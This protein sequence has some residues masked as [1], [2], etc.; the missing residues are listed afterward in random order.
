M[1]V[2]SIVAFVLRKQRRDREFALRGSGHEVARSL[3]LF[4][5]A[6][7]AEIGGAWLIWQGSKSTRAGRGSAL[8][9][10]R[11]CA[12]SPSARS[13][14]V[15]RRL[16][17]GFG[18]FVGVDVF[19]VISGFLIT[20]AAAPRARAT[21]PVSARRFYAR[22][23]RRLLPAAAV[24]WSS[25]AVVAC[26]AAAPTRR[27]VGGDV[28]CGGALR[29]RTS[30]R[31]RAADYLAEDARR[32]R[33]S[34][35]GRSR[36]RS[37]STSSG[38]CWSSLARG[39][40]SAV[41]GGRACWSRGRRHRRPLLVSLC[42]TPSAARP[43]FFVSTTR[44]LGAGGRRAA[45]RSRCPRPCSVPACGPRRLLA[46]GPGW[47]HRLSAHAGPT[48]LARHGALLPV[49][50]TAAGIWPAAAERPWGAA[51]CSAWAPPSDR[52]AVLLALPLALADPRRRPGHLGRP[53]GPS[54]P[55][56]GGRLGGPGLAVLPLPRAPAAPHPAAP[57]PR[58]RPALL[59]GAAGTVLASVAGAALSSRRTRWSTPSRPRHGRRGAGR[60]C[61]FAGP[62]ATPTPTGRRSGTRRPA[63]PVTPC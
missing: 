63:P 30:L 29:R 45:W 27:D 50:G 16:R 5:A 38:R 55:G 6:A 17:P 23:A 44:G 58:P 18:G 26:S 14:L 62:A 15:P 39:S 56:R 33:S 57:R 7:L 43:G 4:V 59:L 49:L 19:F 8:E 10:S 13:L 2:L 36:S 1:A 42:T 54:D 12:P 11:G 51:G 20:G 47:R 46:L 25:R 48:T 31:L 52:R 28:V 21:R 24:C 32:R 3:I 9:S 40:R 60:P 61:A 37:S 41:G 34:T 35:T 22:R 53:A